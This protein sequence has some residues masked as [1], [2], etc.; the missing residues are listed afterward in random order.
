MGEGVYTMSDSANASSSQGRLFSPTLSLVGFGVLLGWHF[1]ILYQPL[2]LAEN[3]TA[4]EFLL[5]RQALLNASLA[6]AFAICGRIFAGLPPQKA[7]GPKRI[8]YGAIAVGTAGSVALVAGTVL[9]ITWTMVAVMLIGAAEAVLMLLWLRFYSETSENYSG[10]SLGASAVI[11]ALIC[12]FA[13]HLT[14]EVSAIVLVA[15]PTISGLL[16]ITATRDIPLRANDPLG[17]GVP[18]WECARRPFAKVTVQLMAMALFFGMAQGCYSSEK[19]LLDIA[20]PTTILGAALAGVVIFAMYS[21]SKLLPNPSPTVNTATVLYLLGMMML[22]FR[23]ELISQMASI[24]IM[25]GFIFYFVLALIF[26]ID[27]VRTFDLNLTMVLGA[28]QALE[29]AMFAF[30]VVSGSVLWAIYEDSLIFPFIIS[31]GAIF[32]LMVITLFFATERPPW[33]AD[34]YKP[35]SIEASADDELEECPEEAEAPA[36]PVTDILCRRFCLTPREAEVFGLLSKGR[37]AE[38]IQ[39]ALFISNHTVK[40]H[41]YNIYRKMGIHSLQELLDLMDAEEAAQAAGAR[42]GDEKGASSEPASRR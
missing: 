40:T 19:T 39:N 17:A 38:F 28:N 23:G 21:R 10:Q 31:Y 11:A 20:D 4:A 35:R 30:G 2:P 29:Y 9:N 37:N 15:L 18:D 42:T 12:F 16:L 1:I 5:A 14:F 8:A 13:H 24:L 7:A 27:L 33:E 41:I 22:P 36:P 32:T 34:Y 3:G 6:L 26:I 25:T